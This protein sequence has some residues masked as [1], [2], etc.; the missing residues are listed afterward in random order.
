[1]INEKNRFKKKEY[2]SLLCIVICLCLIQ[3]IFLIVKQ[4]VFSGTT[5][6][7]YTRSMVTC[8]SMIAAF[9]V[10][11][12]YCRRKKYSLSVFPKAFGLPYVI[13]TLIAVSFYAVTLLFVNKVSV[14]NA[15][16]LFYGSIVTPLFEE[17]LFRGAIWNRVN[18]FF[19]KEWKTYLMVTALFALWHIG[20]AV[21]LYL[22]NGGN[23]FH[24][25]MMKVLVGAAF[26]TLIGAI[27][28]KTKNCYLGILVRGVLNAFG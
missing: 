22:W 27:R 11:V 25:I 23:L 5:E 1:M 28:Y 6:T 9:A 19:D 24:C 17:L 26:G 20:Y 13:A 15:L 14:Q 7:L 10:M 2:K 4:I 21:G 12:L 8:V 3:I 16:M 18:N